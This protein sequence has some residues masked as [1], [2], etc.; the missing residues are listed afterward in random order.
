MGIPNAKDIK[1]FYYTME[2]IDAEKYKM[3]IA[4]P[5]KKKL[6]KHVMKLSFKDAV[7]KKQM[8]DTETFSIAPRF[9]RFLEQGVNKHV[10]EVSGY[11]KNKGVKLLDFK[12]SEGVF[13]K[14]DD[15]YWLCILH[16]TGFYQKE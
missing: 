13:K 1:N 12:V 5:V 2:L 3:Q 15:K 8:D 14:D 9:N 6:F 16:I 10:K 7:S 4:L 11:A